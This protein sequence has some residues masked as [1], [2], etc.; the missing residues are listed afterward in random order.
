M[1]SSCKHSNKNIFVIIH[2]RIDPRISKP[3]RNEL[4][5]FLPTKENMPGRLIE[6]IPLLALFIAEHNMFWKLSW[7]RCGRRE[8]WITFHR[9]ATQVCLNAQKGPGNTTRA[10]V[11]KK[12]GLQNVS[13]GLRFWRQ[14]DLKYKSNK[15]HKCLLSHS[16]K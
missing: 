9:Q 13:L 15:L 16:K 3:W 11:F 4:C 5:S 1:T 7:C 14:H 2:Y 8:N 10:S 6:S 12:K